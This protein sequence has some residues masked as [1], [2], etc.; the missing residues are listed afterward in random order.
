MI[1]VAAGGSLSMRFKRVNLPVLTLVGI[2][3][4]LLVESYTL[5]WQ[6][7][8]HIRIL[9]TSNKDLLRAEQFLLL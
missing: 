7:S 5:L 8:I 4:V 1:C 2:F 6:F 9:L 3:T